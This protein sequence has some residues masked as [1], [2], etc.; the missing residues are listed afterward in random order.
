[1]YLVDM[2]CHKCIDYA[3]SLLEFLK[4]KYNVS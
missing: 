2:K 3:R 1:M 4:L